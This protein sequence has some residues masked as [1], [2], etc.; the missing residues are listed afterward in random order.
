MET[1]SNNVTDY[2]II[3]LSEDLWLFQQVG[4]ESIYGTFLEI[5]LIALIQ[6]SFNFNE[7][8]LAIQHMIEEDH[9]AAHF[10]MW[11]SFIYSFNYKFSHERKAS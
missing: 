4:E 2:N 5:F 1:L 10:G 9:N 6:Y 3:E 11:K 8:E 7:L